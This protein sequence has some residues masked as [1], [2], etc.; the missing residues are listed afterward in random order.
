MPQ[1]NHNM[2]IT[3]WK[4]A[5]AQFPSALQDVY[6]TPEYHR[7]HALEGE[8]LT[9][10]SSIT[11]GTATLLVPGLKLAIPRLRGISE[12]TS[13]FDIQTCNGYGGPLASP[14]AS[15]DFL[16]S[17]WEHWRRECAEQNIVAAFFRL[18]PLLKNEQWLPTNAR[19]LQDRQTVF[20]DLKGGASEA[21]TRADSRHRNMVN[22]GRREG[23][24]IR[25]DDPDGWRDFE[26]LYREAMDRL[27]APP[28]LRFSHAFFSALQALPGT[29]LA[30]VR[31]NGQLAAASVFMFGPRWAH[32]HLSARRKDAGNHLTNYILQGAIEQAC[33]KN[34][35]GLHLGGGRTRSS[36]D[37]L[38]K[39]KLSLGGR[40]LDFKVALVVADTTAYDRLCHAWTKTCGRAP[41]WLLGYRQPSGA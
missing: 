9:C 11:D 36:T 17:A 32:Y 14:D 18:H 28:E 22:K 15:S 39:F 24:S 16:E 20:V 30:C 35:E 29:E 5:L 4:S 33:Q 40:L 38:L 12:K 1:L 34:M 41:E 8:C 13:G 2:D 3:E 21:W 10:C 26:L 25:W 27:N 7:L 31:T 23:V 6:F 19:I 37:N